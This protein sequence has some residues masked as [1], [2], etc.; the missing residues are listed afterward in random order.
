[1]N[2]GASADGVDAN[3]IARP[4]ADGDVAGEARERQRA[5]RIEGEGRVEVRAAG[6]AALLRGE[7][8]RGGS[9]RDRDK[10]AAGPAEKR[11]KKS[12]IGCSAPVRQRRRGPE[13][14]DFA[15]ERVVERFD[16]VTAG[17]V[18][19]ERVAALN[20]G[21]I[22]DAQVVI[23]NAHGARVELAAAL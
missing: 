8:G 9:E 2:V 18:A 22:D 15:L 3:F 14:F 1:A 10:G 16:E 23:E 4:G 13:K 21:G 11:I 12:H 5:A 6:V 17:R 20:D 7:R 19:L